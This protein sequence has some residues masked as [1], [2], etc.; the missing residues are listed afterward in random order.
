MKKLFFL[1]TIIIALSS[2]EIDYIA[3]GVYLLDNR[4][5]Y[6]VIVVFKHEEMEEELSKQ[7]SKNT[8]DTMY[9]IRV[10]PAITQLPYLIDYIKIYAISENAEKRL[11]Y[12]QNKP[13]DENPWKIDRK[14]WRRNWYHTTNTFIFTDNLIQR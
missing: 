13:V 12:E 2:C 10:E 5:S 14:Y 11:L 1:I 3:E 4:S 7:I 8:L 6:D 9:K